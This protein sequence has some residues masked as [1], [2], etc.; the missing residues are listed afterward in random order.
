MNGLLEQ[1]KQVATTFYN[2]Q[3]LYVVWAP[4]RLMYFVYFFENKLCI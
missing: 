1:K 2:V 4:W 3:Y